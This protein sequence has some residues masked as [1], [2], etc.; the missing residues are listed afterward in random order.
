MRSNRMGEEGQREISQNARGEEG[1]RFIGC[2]EKR[3]SSD[4][5]GHPSREKKP[6]KKRASSEVKQRQ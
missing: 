5:P 4:A 1:R 2:L 6:R 3:S